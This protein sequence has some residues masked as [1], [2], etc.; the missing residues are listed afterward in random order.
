MKLER[1]VP[2]C[3]LSGVEGGGAVEVVATRSYGPDAVEVTWRGPDGLGDR[4]LY[5]EDEARS[6][7]GHFGAHQVTAVADT[8]SFDHKYTSGV[9][10]WEP[11]DQ[12]TDEQLGAAVDA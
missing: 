10:A 3:R 4:I 2:G 5:R 11:E 12:P 6:Q 7:G 9:I 8:L 1:I